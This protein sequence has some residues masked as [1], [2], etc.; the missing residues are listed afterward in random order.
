MLFW[1]LLHAADLALWGV[2]GLYFFLIFVA[3]MF[4][5]VVYRAASDCSSSFE[6]APTVC[7]SVVKTGGDWAHIT[8]SQVL[9]CVDCWSC[10]MPMVFFSMFGSSYSFALCPFF[11][12]CFRVITFG[13]R[14]RMCACGGPAT[15]HRLAR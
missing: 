7:R 14:V 5:R 3:F 2:T 11:A 13:K 10:A 4:V 15:T 9:A 8:G 1:F 12:H 6:R